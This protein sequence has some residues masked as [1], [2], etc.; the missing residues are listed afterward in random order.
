MARPEVENAARRTGEDAREKAETGSGWYAVL[1]RSGLVAKGVS[2]GLVGVLALKL[3]V[4]DGGKATSRQGALQALQ[5]A[6]RSSSSL[7][8]QSAAQASG[9]ATDPLA[10]AIS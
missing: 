1:A 3:A 10:P 6:A 7:R 8:G 2:Y 9:A 5:A 4:G